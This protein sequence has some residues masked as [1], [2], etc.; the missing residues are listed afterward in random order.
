MANAGPEITAAQ[1]E[2]GDGLAG[3]YC[4]NRGGEFKL[5][6]RTVG[7]EKKPKKNLKIKAK[8]GSETLTSADL[9]LPVEYLEGSKQSRKA[10]RNALKKEK[11]WLKSELPTLQGTGFDSRT[12]EVTLLV[13]GGPAD[14]ARAAAVAEDLERRIANP[15]RATVRNVIVQPTPMRGG[16]ALYTSSGSPYCTSA[17]AGKDAAGNAGILTAGHCTKTQQFWKEGTALS[18]LSGTPYFNGFE[19]FVLLRGSV[20]PEPKFVANTGEIRTLTGRRT[21]ANTDT[22]LDLADPRGSYVCVY[23]RVSGPARGQTCGEVNDVWFN[24]EYPIDTAKGQFGCSNGPTAVTCEF[25]YVEIVPAGTTPLYCLGGDSG[26]PVFTYTI[27][28]GIQSGCGL[29]TE[30]AGNPTGQAY[31]I[32]YTSTDELYYYNYSLMFGA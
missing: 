25:N 27:A 17:F 12:G 20:A 3:A 23:G 32:I 30:A 16:T 24:P 15:V 26:A 29:Y 18:A 14:E 11:A 19:D 21:K 22:K 10:L 9:D 4:E 13:R 5:V 31:N 7:S 6:I 8:R 28:F 2:L 1:L